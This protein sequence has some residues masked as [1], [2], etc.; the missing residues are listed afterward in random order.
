[1]SNSG[2]LVPLVLSPQL[3]KEQIVTSYDFNMKTRNLILDLN[4]KYS[5]KKIICPLEP[6]WNKTIKT[7]EQELRKKAI[8]QH[9]IT[10]L[11]DTADANWEIFNDSES[12]GRNGKSSKPSKK[13][14][15]QKFRFE[16]ALAEAVIVGGK[17]YFAI[18]THE[19]ITLEKSIDNFI[20]HS[21]TS[22]M[23]R[24]Y[25]FKSK[26]E[27]DEIV[28][29][30]KHET[31]DALYLKV[32]AQWRKFSTDDDAEI[33]LCAADTILTYLQD[34][35][36]MTHYIFF[37]GAPDSGKSNRLMV[38][39]F[40]AYRN[41]MSTDVTPS[42]IYRFFGSQQE[43]QGT[44]CE[45]EADDLDEFPQK[46]KI[47]KSGYTTGFKVARNED[48]GGSGGG[49]SQD[50]YCTF[51]F[52]AF[53]AEKVP[54]TMKAK[55]LRQRLIEIKCL[56]GTPEWDISEVANPAFA[57]EFVKQ[58][59]GLKELRNILFVYRLVHFNDKIPNIKLNIA[60]RE[61]QLFKPLLRVFQ[62]TDT[63]KELLEVV[64]HFVRER[65]ER[66][67]D[68]LH[69][70]LF[71]LMEFLV[72]C[73]KKHQHETGIIW[74]TLK[75]WLPG[76]EIPHKPLSY[77]SE[78]FGTISQKMIVEIL[79]NDFSARRPAHKGP[80]KE[81]IFDK[82]ILAGLKEKY[83]TDLKVEVSQ[84]QEDSSS[85]RIESDESHE[86][87]VQGKGEGV[88]E[89]PEHEGTDNKSPHTHSKEATH[90]THATQDD[91]T[92]T[93]EE[94]PDLESLQK[95]LQERDK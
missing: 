85:K 55:G 8:K 64:S 14:V 26:E 60:N 71:R 39:N 69:S 37:V 65:R 15:I 12:E 86:S 52:K 35:L 56:S 91:S 25:V 54:D 93:I 73:H 1:M 83:H 43:G 62:N 88:S 27:F 89:G 17:S 30:A 82:E 9:H 20:P 72:D 34:V 94:D 58:L 6:K 29:K 79:E 24:P 38:F 42:N 21:A 77:E 7:L 10:M 76:S 95:E 36:G 59:H 45:D 13:S 81:L 41:F 70:T 40:L 11:T 66:N 22:Y 92:R 61:K 67:T 74:K 5:K 32:K 57:D 33:S 87:D 16:H 4:H 80:K 75:D 47:Y 63:Q 48:E 51:G 53:A 23:N 50:A 90:P 18:A 28:E 3:E 2:N 49:R 44:I 31:L 84:Q 78:Q 68:T 46:M 19:G